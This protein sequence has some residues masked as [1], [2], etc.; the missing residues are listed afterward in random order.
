MEVTRQD[1]TF[2]D[3]FKGKIDT[4]EEDI[5]KEV[6]RSEFYEEATD[7]EISIAVEDTRSRVKL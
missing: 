2:L 4:T 5:E 3:K 7:D 6:R 1:N